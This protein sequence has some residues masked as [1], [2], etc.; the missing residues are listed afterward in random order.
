MH[1]RNL[2][3]APPRWNP[4]PGG[5]PCWGA[6][7]L[8]GNWLQFADWKTIGFHRIHRLNMVKSPWHEAISHSC[9]KIIG[10]Y[11]SIFFPSILELV[12]HILVLWWPC[13]KLM[14]PKFQKIPL[15][16]KVV[17]W[18]IYIFIYVFMC[19]FIYIHPF[20]NKTN[21]KLPIKSQG[22]WQHPTW[23]A[24]TPA[25]YSWPPSER[26]RT[27]S[28]QQHPSVRSIEKSDPTW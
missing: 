22:V 13:L 27:S 23:I 25:I 11:L 20:V 6:L 14:L 28:I 12:G 21:I 2:A 7:T 1:T 9:G 5:L 16:F 19:L 10:G 17:T 3:I 26:H 15:N 18:Y 4:E 24:A 8:Q